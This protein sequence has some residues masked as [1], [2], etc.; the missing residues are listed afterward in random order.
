MKRFIGGHSKGKP[1]DRERGEDRM[2]LIIKRG[3][4]GS[5]Y[6]NDLV[7]AKGTG[8]K[9]SS[10][11]SPGTR[12]KC[13]KQAAKTKNR[14]NMGHGGKSIVGKTKPADLRAITG[15]QQE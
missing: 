14:P 1:I 11:P 7:R 9:E 2:S 3:W 15:S 4:L 13:S 6:Q 8:V 10:E 12:L 5:A